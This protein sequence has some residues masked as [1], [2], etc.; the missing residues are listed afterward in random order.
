MR[1]APVVLVVGLL[2][3][4]SAQ[5]AA[6]FER[7]L[8]P[9]GSSLFNRDLHLGDVDADGHLDLFDLSAD[10]LDVA[11]GLGGFAF[12]ATVHSFV[13]ESPMHLS[14]GHV[15]GDAFLDA[16]VLVGPSPWQPVHPLARYFPYVTVG[17]AITLRSCVRE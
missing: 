4:A 1:V 12:G 17:S 15:D 7:A 6:V 5:Q 16:V 8:W 2:G 14:V 11:R 10:G 9:V 3:A 13:G